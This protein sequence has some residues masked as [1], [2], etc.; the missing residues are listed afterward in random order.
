MTW[1]WGAC[2]N[3]D[4]AQSHD[5][6]LSSISIFLTVALRLKIFAATSL[7]HLYDITSGDLFWKYCG[8]LSHV[9]LS[10]EMLLKLMWFIPLFTNSSLTKLRILLYDLIC[11]LETWQYLSQVGARGK[12]SRSGTFLVK[13]FGRAKKCILCGQYSTLLYSTLLYSTLLYSTLLYS[14][15]LYSTLLYSTLLYSTLLY[16]TLLYSTLLYSTLLYSTLLY[17]T[18]LYS[19]LLYSTLLY[20]TLLYSTLLY[21]TLLYST[22][23]YSTL[24]YPTLPYP[25][26]PYPTLPYPTLPYPTLPNPTL[27]YPTLPYPTL[28]YSTLL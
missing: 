7:E 12:H 27:P 14:T 20:S 25:T 6:G 9:L 26:L 13:T 15:L 5:G 3:G 16:S 22:L 19:T 2:L 24:L 18:L 10:C 11:F 21:S 4:E 17:S 8:T 23:L 1:P 28:P